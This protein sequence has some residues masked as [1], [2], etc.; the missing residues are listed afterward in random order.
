MMTI[1]RARSRK[2]FRLDAAKIKRAPKM[3]RGSTE[4]ETIER[5][6]DLPISEYRSNRMGAEAKECFVGNHI[7]I[8]DIYGTLRA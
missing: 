6:L 2:H 5:A 7:K 4:T 8:K 1:S 3:L